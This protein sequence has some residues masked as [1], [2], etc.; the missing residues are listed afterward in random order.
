M[1]NTTTL[2]CP[3]CGENFLSTYDVEHS[4]Q[5]YTEECAVCCKPITVSVRLDEQARLIEAV[6]R[7][8]DD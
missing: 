5:D 2:Q 8:Y 6:A 1:H 4:Q 7:R 3:Y